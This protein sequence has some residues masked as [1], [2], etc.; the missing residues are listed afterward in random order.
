MHIGDIDPLSD[1]QSKWIK[2][3]Y[4]NMSPYEALMI[5]RLEQYSFSD[6]EVY[7][8]TVTWCYK[9]IVCLIF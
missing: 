8:N 5:R 2:Y 9:I 6:G 4:L 3:K 7:L 1:K